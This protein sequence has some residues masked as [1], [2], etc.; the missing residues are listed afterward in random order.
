M[1]PAAHDDII[2]AQHPQRELLLPLVL[3]QVPGLDL[4]FLSE[5][6]CPQGFSAR[7]SFAPSGDI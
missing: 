1:A 6:A 4:I 7:A 2:L 3:V 5:V